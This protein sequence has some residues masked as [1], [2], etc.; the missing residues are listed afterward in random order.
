MR[1]CPGAEVEGGP[2]CQRTSCSPTSP[3]RE[4]APW[5]ISSAA[6]RTRATFRSYGAELKEIYF[7]MG[8]YDYVVVAHA[9]DDETITRVSLAVSGQGN[10]RTNTFRV[11]TEQEALGLIEG[12]S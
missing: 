6:S 9:P 11:F 4:R 7:A 3:T 8:Q 5:R 10:V 1:R 12:A 2:Q